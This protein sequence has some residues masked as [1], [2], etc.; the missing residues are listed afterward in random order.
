M[1]CMPGQ[2]LVFRTSLYCAIQAV[3]QFR[4]QKGKFSVAGGCYLLVFQKDKV[5]YH[6]L[7]LFLL[8]WLYMSLVGETQ[9]ESLCARLW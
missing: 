2:K 8:V 9:H 7:S 4:F 3:G 1:P 6:S 5:L